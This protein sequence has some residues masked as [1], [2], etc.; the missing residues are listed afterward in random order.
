MKRRLPIILV[1]LLVCS[2]SK[3]S[4]ITQFPGARAWSLANAGLTFSD[5]FSVNNN[6]AGLGFLKQFTAGIYS[7]RR[8]RLAELQN[9]CL[10]LA[11]PT[12]TGVWGLNLNYFGYSA[13]NEQQIGL[14]YGRAFTAKFSA[15]IKLNFHSVN[16]QEYGSKSSFTVEG[17]MLAKI[18]E[19]LSFAA[20]IANPNQVKLSSYQ[21]ER[22]PTRGKLGLTYRPSSKVLLVMEAE[23]TLSSSLIIK[24]GIA[25][26]VRN[27]L[28]L[29]LGIATNPVLNCYGFGYTQKCFQLDVAASFHPQFGLTPHLSIIYK[30][31]AK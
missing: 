26:K 31:K 19:Q 14:A 5:V 12:S 2:Q 28:E 1:L 20:H 11:V 22:I 10:V 18:S 17:G 4:Y 9:G 3:A 30:Q 8:F 23:K 24:T 6:Q 29:R 25:Y 21:N 16:I 7:E 27:D 15:G 13:Y